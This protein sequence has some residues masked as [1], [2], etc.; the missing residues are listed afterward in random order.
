M[1]SAK[2]VMKIYF[3]MSVLMLMLMQT[4]CSPTATPILPT[5]TAVPPLATST[6]I[7]TSTLPPTLTPIPTLEKPQDTPTA[8]YKPIELSSADNE[9]YQKALEDIALYR[10]GELQITIQ[11]ERGNPLPGYAVKYHQTSHEFLFGGVADPFYA[12]QLR[13]SGINTMT[14]YMDWR[15]LEPEYGKFDLD[16]TNYW[17]GID[18]LKSAGM[19]VKTNNLFNTSDTDIAPYFKDVPYDEF[20]EHLHVHIAT[21]VQKFAPSVDYW[22]AILE[23]NF[24]NHNPLNLTKDQYYGA[25]ATSIAAIRE[26]DPTATIEINLSYPCGGIDWL[27]N[28]QLVQEMLDRQIDFDVLGLQLYYNAYIVDGNYPMPRMSF[29]EMSA[30]YD[31][32]EKMLVPYGKKVVGSE[33]SVPSEAIPGPSGYWDQPWSEATQAQ[34]LTTAFTIFFSKPSNLGLIWWN[35]VEPSPFVYNGGLVKDDGAPKKS[36]YALQG[37]IDGW[38]T[39]GAGYTDTNGNINIQGFGGDYAIEISDPATGS[40]MMTQMHLAEQTSTNQDVKF[41]PNDWL[42]QQ[43]TQ[44]EKLVAYWDTEAE[45]KR[46]QKGRDYLALIDHHTQNLEWALAKQ[47]LSAALGELAITTEVVIPNQNLIPIGYRGEG[48]TIENGSNL[49]WSSTILQLPYDF[50]AGTV[51]VEISA[52]S[53]NEKGEAPIMVA[54]VGANYSPMW[55][56]ENELSQVYTF[57]VTTTGAEQ[58]LTIRFPYDGRV[59]DNI[60]TQGGDV[61]ELKLYI[62]QVK[63]MIKT[64]EI[65]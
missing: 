9:T 25:I 33:F 3:Q 12:S 49:I 63:L 43:K 23:P 8:L 37:L 7:P 15:W 18:E 50:P 46:A 47:T 26:N 44:L 55:K 32:Y 14:A 58:V 48:F 13:Q 40:S 19:F 65:P 28:F 35:S 38:T 2:I 64:A 56:V 62:D 27:D 41:I 57:S 61:G 5:K 53:H 21:T 36:F 30:C 31:R 52:H 11:D 17:L 39:N 60:T 45:Q 59:L 22:E 54:G 24:G 20:L 16:F 1:N 42:D 51:T 4:S 10:Q 29:S 34:Y 6:L